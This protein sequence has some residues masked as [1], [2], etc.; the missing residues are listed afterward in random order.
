MNA[1]KKQHPALQR[2]ILREYIRQLKGDLLDINFSHIENLLDHQTASGSGSLPGLSL[3][4]RKGFLYPE[5]FRVSPYHYTAKSFGTIA[6]NETGKKI[7][8]KKT[9]AFR[10]PRNNFE[11]IAPLKT[12]RFPIRIRNANR[13]DAYIKLNSGIKQSVFEMIRS[14][15]IPSELRGLWPLILDAGDDPV[16]VAGS[17]MAEPF[18]V[19]EKK[20]GPFIRI[21][22]G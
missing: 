10:T 1:L 15:G 2:F 6:L 7:S 9:N 13:N 22:Y 5:N 3:K 16:W 12:L 11:M 17:P 19:K 21:S 8:I 20:Q 18:K 4:Y 14:G